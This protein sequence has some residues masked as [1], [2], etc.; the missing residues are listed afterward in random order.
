MSISK[1]TWHTRTWLSISKRTK[2]SLSLT[3]KVLSPTGMEVMGMKSL[4]SMLSSRD[5]HRMDLVDSLQEVMTATMHPTLHIITQEK[6]LNNRLAKKGHGESSWS[7][8]YTLWAR[9]PTEDSLNTCWLP[10]KLLCC[11][12]RSTIIGM[13]TSVHTFSPDGWPI[14]VILTCH[15]MK[16]PT[17][18]TA[19]RPTQL[20]VELKNT[21]SSACW[22]TAPQHMTTQWPRKKTRPNKKPT[23]KLNL[24]KKQP[25][26]R[27]KSH[28]AR[29]KFKSNNHQ[30][31]SN[32]PRTTSRPSQELVLRKQQ[33]LP[34]Q[35]MP[36]QS[37]K[38]RREI[39]R[40]RQESEAWLITILIDR[41]K[42]T[43]SSTTSS[44]MPT[45]KT[46]QTFK[47]TNTIAWCKR[48]TKNSKSLAEWT[49]EKPGCKF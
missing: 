49:I 27:I 12:K 6:A 24:S 40:R 17:F 2:T 28:Q 39:P 18:T 13:V 10:K 9:L 26:P 22:A 31:R 33:T 37:K 7:S 25:S 30:R 8:W 21:S 14:H 47:R 4:L 16:Q 11:G 41:W 29:S 19:L 23:N 42:N 43:K 38:E 5:W 45:S 15:L 34:R 32:S 1:G 20:M 48:Q 36:L 44:S 46:N 3:L 35:Q